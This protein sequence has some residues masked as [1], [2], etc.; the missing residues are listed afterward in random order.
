VKLIVG[1]GN[2]GKDYKLSRHNVGF[3]ALDQLSTNTKI[4]LPKKR[5]RSIFGHGV[6]A[7]TQVLLAKPLTF[8]NLSGNAISAL[9]HFYNLAPENIIVIHD[10]IDVAFGH[11]KVKNQGG[12]GGHRGIESIIAS[13]REDNF[14]RIR[15]GVGRPPADMDP[16]DY[17]LASFTV[18]EQQEL[19]EVVNRIQHCIE[20][21]LI[22]GP[23]AAMNIFHQQ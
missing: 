10:D 20:I 4:S 9:A 7:G 18:E 22:Q 13:L 6:I 2:P 3:V 19:K 1:L 17:V 5:F 21:I 11:L 8:M 23:K 12:S 15:V 14:V 16:S